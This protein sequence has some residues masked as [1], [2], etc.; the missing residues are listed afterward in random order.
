MAPYRGDAYLS[1]EEVEA[2]LRHLETLAPE[3]VQL[4]EV[5]RSVAGLG[6]FVIRIGASDDAP[7]V[8]IDGGTHACEWVS[9]MAAVYMASQWTEALRDNDARTRDQFRRATAYVMPCVCPDGFDAVVRG[10]HHSLRSSLRPASTPR[11]GGLVP[12]DLTGDGTVRCMRWPCPSGAWVKD[13]DGALRA[14]SP[15]DAPTDAFALSVEGVFEAGATGGELD[16]RCDAPHGHPVDVNR[17]QPD[18]WAPSAQF[19]HSGGAFPLSEPEARCQAD[20]VAARPTIAAALTMH[21]YGGM[22]F[23][24]PYRPSALSSWNVALGQ[25]LGT[26]VAGED[27]RATPSY[28]DN[29]YDTTAPTGGKWSETLWNVFGIPGFTLELWDACAH[30]GVPVSNMRTFLCDASVAEKTVAAHDAAW[31]VFEHH[32]LGTIEVGGIDYM[33][34]VRNP[35]TELLAMELARA[36]RVA[37]RLMRCLPAL[38]VQLH[39]EEVAKDTHRVVA[40]VDNEGYL[41]TSGTHD[42]PTDVLELRM[43]TTATLLSPEVVH[44][45]SLDGWG[46]VHY[47]PGALPAA[48]YPT[49]GARGTRTRAAWLVRGSGHAAVEVFSAR[50]GRTRREIFV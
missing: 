43:T 39:V 27:Y 34:T 25:D 16:L 40:L 44:A 36:M 49:L 37:E 3:W 30:A 33:Y 5:G 28:P 47:R 20:A 17:N 14:R 46:A 41:P 13:A 22:L 15:D 32:Q 2:T 38:Q 9:V 35:P 23:T 31:V 10:A 8:W 11:R 45:A 26:R 48:L 19:G 21:S 42:R 6:I 29:V 7:A 24:P 18:H 50:S 12:S 1:W 4:K